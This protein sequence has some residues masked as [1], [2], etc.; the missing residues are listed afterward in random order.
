MAETPTEEAVAQ[1]RAVGLDELQLAA[2]TLFGD[3]FREV[4]GEGTLDVNWDHYLDIEAR[5][6][7]FLLGAYVGDVLVGYSA[8]YRYRHPFRATVE[9]L[10]GFAIYVV[11]WWRG[12]GVG[13]L[14][15]DSTERLSEELGCEI[16]FHHTPDSPFGKLL[17]R[18]G[19]S[20]TQVSR[21]KTL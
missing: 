3:H 17:D 8:C 10:E 4:M 16:Q 12:R 5:G 2:G 13:L 6:G 9:V 7:L 11:E 15:I 19:Y 18:R 21:S 14:L 1:V 20:T